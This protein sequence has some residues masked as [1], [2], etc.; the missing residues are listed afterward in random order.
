MEMHRSWNAAEWRY[1]LYG[2]SEHQRRR[3]EQSLFSAVLL[4]PMQSSYGRYWNP[5]YLGL[6]EPTDERD[7]L[8]WL[9]ALF[10]PEQLLHALDE[11]IAE[12]KRSID[13]W[14]TLPYPDRLQPDFG[15]S[16]GTSLNFR[17]PEDRLEALLWWV[18]ACLRKW[19]RS[20]FAHSLKLRG[21]RWPRE[22][23]V[24]DDEALVRALGR[25]VRSKGLRFMWLAHY[26][27]AHVHAWKDMGF[28]FMYVNPGYYGRSDVPVEYI[29]YAALFASTVGSGLQLVCGKGSLCDRGHPYEYWRRGVPSRLD[30]LDRASLMFVFQETDLVDLARTRKQLYRDL[31]HVVHGIRRRRGKA[32]RINR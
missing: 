12:A 29:D 18:D 13:I 7:W 5:L 15:R 26:G 14:I 24:A 27:S 10:A 9:V 6:T 1:V 19:K 28:D 17:Y 4:T 8:E 23:L 22:V 11:A 16:S 2:N 21:F 32:A 20:S 25:H 3:T 31:V 30:Y